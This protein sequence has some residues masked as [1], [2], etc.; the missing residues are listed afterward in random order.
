MKKCCGPR[1]PACQITQVM[2]PVITFQNKAKKSRNQ[3]LF[4]FSSSMRLAAHSRLH[5]QGWAG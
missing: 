2:P 1:G 5:N 4:L 3:P